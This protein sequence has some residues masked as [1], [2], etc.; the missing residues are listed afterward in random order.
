MIR[1]GNFLLQHYS[2]QESQMICYYVFSLIVDKHFPPSR[3]EYLDS[4]VIF[5]AKCIRNATKL[6]FIPLF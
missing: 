4:L 1:E 5:H 2:S 3:A 6:L